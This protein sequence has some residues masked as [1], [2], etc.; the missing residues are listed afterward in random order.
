MKTIV[1]DGEGSWEDTS[2]EN[3][4]VGVGLDGRVYMVMSPEVSLDML[5]PTARWFAAELLVAADRAEAMA[6]K[7]VEKKEG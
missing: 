7:N 4:V 6:A 1:V 5:G 2:C 3:P